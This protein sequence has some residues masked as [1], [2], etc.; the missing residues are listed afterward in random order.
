M[1][2]VHLKSANEGDFIV[3]SYG[4]KKISHILI[5]G[6]VST[7]GYDFQEI[8][9]QIYNNGEVI[10]A[11]I[12]THIDNDHINGAL[13][14][15][16][17][18]DGDILQKTIKKIYFNTCEGIKREQNIVD[19]CKNNA[20]DSL[21]VMNHSKGYGVDEAVS[22]LEMLEYKKIRD[23]LVDYVVMGNVLELDKEAILK[24]ISPGKKELEKLYKK[25]E[26]GKKK[27]NAEGY[28]ANF[29]LA[30]KDLFELKKEI[31][32]SDGS[33]NNKSSIAFLFEYKGIKIAFLADANSSVCLKGLKKFEKDVY[34]ADAVK[35]SHHGS[36]SNTSDK[37]LKKINTSNYLLSTDGHGGDVPSKVVI[38]HML[39][40]KKEEETVNLYCNYPWWRITYH[41]KYFTKKDKEMY[42]D[43]EKL[44]V[45][46]L[47][48][49]GEKLKD[50][51]IVYGE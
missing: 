13:D 36:R 27:R 42:I 45:I 21:K 44:K 51:L 50:G 28:A 12:L 25:W 37:L 47:S 20:E 43:K 46:E 35:V 30:E 16:G 29:E 22:F 33:V 15:I 1:V 26:D 38:A 3:I 32:Y 2:E 34:N 7:N 8:V 31:L 11:L 18:L 14:G 6:G 19:A 4:D 23:K 49:K 40:M 48:D 5:D 41:N 24:V 10:E 39:H 17:R 9:Q